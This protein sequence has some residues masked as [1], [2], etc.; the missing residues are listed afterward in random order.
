MDACSYASDLTD[1]E[2]ALLAPLVPRSHPAGRRQ[3]YPLRRIVDAIFYLLRARGNVTLTDIR[4]AG[5]NSAD[6]QAQAAARA[7]E[8]HSAMALRR[9]RW[10]ARAERRERGGTKRLRTVENTLTNLCRPPCDRNPCIARSRLRTGRCEF[11]A[12]L[13][14][15]LCE[16]CST[17]GMIWCRAAA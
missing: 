1:A 13:F 16:R 8:F 10:M 9:C 14:R 5:T 7:T 4:R 12:R 3:T 11:S 15:P 2:W 6:R 17:A